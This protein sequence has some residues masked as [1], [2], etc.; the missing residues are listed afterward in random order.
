M[1]QIKNEKKLARLK[2]RLME[3]ST[4]LKSLVEEKA[5]LEKEIEQLE[6]AA[7]YGFIKSSKITVNAAFLQNLELAEAL[8]N[9]GYTADDVKQLLEINEKTEVKTDEKI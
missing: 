1:A 6:A 8:S 5:S 2:S 3:V 9:S 7:V 4:Q